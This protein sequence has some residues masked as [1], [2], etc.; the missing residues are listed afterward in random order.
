MKKLLV[1]AS[2]IFVACTT[3]EPTVG[4]KAAA[5]YNEF[6]EKIK[7]AQSIEDI[8]QIQ[9]ESDFMDRMSALQ[10]EWD[11]LIVNGDSSNYYAE[12]LKVQAAKDSLKHMME[13]KFAGFSK[14]IN[15][16]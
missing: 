9:N 10:P 13:I 12:E 14:Q 15:K 2:F 1:I 16:E 5:I 11:A 6:T 7:A 8:A 3:N 4:D